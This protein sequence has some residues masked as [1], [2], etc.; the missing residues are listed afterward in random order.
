[1]SDTTQNDSREESPQ[2]RFELMQADDYGKYLLHSKKEILFILRAM[3][4]KGS[5]ITVYFLSL[6]HI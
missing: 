2:L 1:M 6:I 3:C 5:L 4:E